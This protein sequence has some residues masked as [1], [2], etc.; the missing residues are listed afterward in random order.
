MKNPGAILSKLT[1]ALINLYKFQTGDLGYYKNFE[2]WQKRGFHIIPNH[3]Y[4]PIPDTR[5]LKNKDFGEKSM[6]GIDLNTSTQLK[7]LNDFAQFQNEFENF[8]Y[9]PKFINTQVDTNFY[10]NNLAFDGIDALSYYSF[11]RLLKP[12]NVIEVGSGWSTKIAASAALKNVNTKLVSIEPY[13]QPFLKKGIP[14]LHKLINKKVENVP[15]S[16]FES[17]GSG[18]ILF[19][20]SS[21]VVKIGGDVTYIFFEILPRLKKGVYVHIHDIF[22]PF[23]YPRDWIIKQRRFWTEQYLLHAFLLFNKTFKIVFSRGYLNAKYPAKVKKTFNQFT[24]EGG[25][26]FWMKKVR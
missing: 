9:L 12:K 6:V 8:S 23:D 14:G 4:H 16:F 3:Y 15:L 17:L 5:E 21:H 1:A 24:P 22:L 13:P 7:F 2:Y 10:F 11:I 19:I 26:S 20:D 18:D 25:G